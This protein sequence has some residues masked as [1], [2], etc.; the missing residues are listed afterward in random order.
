MKRVPIIVIAVVVAVAA[1]CG[2]FLAY[3]AAPAGTAPAGA[4]PADENPSALFKVGRGASASAVAVDLESSHRIRSARA[5][6][7]LARLTG[8]DAAIKAGTYRLPSGAPMHRILALLAEGKKAEV[9]VTIPEGLTA[10]MTANLLE[11]AGVCAADDFMTET[12]RSSLLSELGIPAASAEGYLFPDTYRMEYD[13]NPAD[14]LRVMV[15]AFRKAVTDIAPLATIASRSPDDLHAA[16]ILASIVER[17][18]RVADEAPLMASVFAN[19]LRIGMPL[20]SCATVV[21]VITE[22]QGKP[23]P[24]TVYYADLAIRDAYN[25]Y[26]NQGLPPGPISNPGRTALSA[27]SS[28][29]GTEYLYFRLADSASGRH[30][31]SRTLEE[32]AQPT[33]SVKGF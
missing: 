8:K 22:K 5:F 10:R 1:G 30:R 13:M 33:L 32:H 19:R 24:S 12:R 29:P 23:H 11:K 9:E 16:V 31:F 2:L 4:A 3:D 6:V 18:Y 7:I 15:G 21:Y 27:V 26:L 14:V 25:T 20:Q 28:P 17:E